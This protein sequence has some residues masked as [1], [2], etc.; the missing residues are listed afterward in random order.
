MRD[1]DPIQREH[2][3][4]TAFAITIRSV[5]V[6]D[7]VIAIAIAIAIAGPPRTP[8]F[9]DFAHRR[10]FLASK[11]AVTRIELDIKKFSREWNLERADRLQSGDG[12]TRDLF[13][14]AVVELVEGMGI[15]PDG[16]RC[17]ASD[18]RC[19]GVGLWTDRRARFGAILSP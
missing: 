13:G 17:R 19:A 12:P 18:G 15:S 8:A 9:N 1:D 3:D 4:A 2:A 11:F 16:L 10:K 6:I 5:I 14:G 7:I